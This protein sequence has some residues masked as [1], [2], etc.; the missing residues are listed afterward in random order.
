MGFNLISFPIFL[1]FHEKIPSYQNYKLP[2]K[3]IIPE[4]MDGKYLDKM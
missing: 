2:G 3:I 4:G 1:Q